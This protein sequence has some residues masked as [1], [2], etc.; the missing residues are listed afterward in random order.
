[1]DQFEWDDAKAALNFE[2]HGI[3]FNDASA[4]LKGLAIS[5]SVKRNGETR[6]SSICNNNGLAIVV[7]WTPRK[8]AIRLISARRAR[9]NEREKYSQA[10]KQSA[11]TR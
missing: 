5:R 4:A 7:I 1:M 9:K 2:K 11:Q 3:G 8:D 10:V 6:F